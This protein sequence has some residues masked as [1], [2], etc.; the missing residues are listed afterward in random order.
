VRFYPQPSEQK[1]EINGQFPVINWDKFEQKL[2][3]IKT[4]EKIQKM[5]MC[6]NDFLPIYDQLIDIIKQTCDSEG[7]FR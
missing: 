1:L 4:P 2:E 3:L 6:I 7:P 5:V